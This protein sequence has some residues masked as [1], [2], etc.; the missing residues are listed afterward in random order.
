MGGLHCKWR[1]PN[2]RFNRHFCRL[3]SSPSFPP[4]SSITS[5]P[6]SPLSQTKVRC[7]EF[8]TPNTRSRAL[9][10]RPLFCLSQNQQTQQAQEDNDRN[11]DDDEEEGEDDDSMSQG[12]GNGNWTIVLSSSLVG[13]L[14]GLGVVLFNYSVHEI[15]DVI[16]DEIPQRGASW[17]REEPI[18]DMWQ[19]V[20][21]VP[22]AG[23]S[24]V[25]ILNVLRGA[26]EDEQG[27]EEEKEE[28]VLVKMG[29]PVSVFD[30][31]K[32]ASR[33][34]LKAVAACVTLGTGNSLGP[35]GPSVEIGTSIAKGVGAVF[36]KSSQRK[37][38]LVAAG[39]AA[40]IASGFN[41][42]VSGCFFA[43]ESVLWPSPADS[44]S[45]SVSLTN[46]TSMVILSAVIAS[47]VTQVGLGSEPA[48]K[49]P[50]YDFR[51]PTELPLYLLL[52]VLC[53]LVSLTFSKCTSYMLLVVDNLQKATS[54]PRSLFPIL[55]GLSVGLIA[56]AYP[57]IL[58]WGFENVDILLESRP[59]VKGLSADLLVQL[60]VVKI[61]ATSLCRASG[62]VGGYY[63]PSL[64]IGAATGMAYGK[65]I[66]SA[67]AQSNPLLHLSYL[68]VAS[69]QAYGLVGMAATLAGVC[70]VPLTAVLLLFELTQDYRI[71]LPL[72][73]AVGLSSWVTSGQ[74]RRKDVSKSKK[75]SKGET[76]SIQQPKERFS[77][78]SGLSSRKAFTESTS[79]MSDLCEM[80]S[81]LCID[82]FDIDTEKLEK[83]ILV[84]EAMRT[85]YVTVWMNTSLTEA[86]AL[87]LAE[88]QPCAMIVDSD[89]VLIGILT[90]EDIQKFSNKYAK[91]RKQPKELI[92]YEMCSSDGEACKVPGTATPSMDLFSAQNI[93][94]RYEMNEIPVVTE[95]PQD[96]RGHLVGLLDRD[97]ISLTCR[98]LATRE[99]LR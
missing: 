36:D 71:V 47:V 39:S 55:G 81:S 15:R 99:S 22:A 60:V 83:K 37:L 46:T 18:T 74:T 10:L 78:V 44:S 72:L 84:S 16:W 92:V 52:G 26:L 94:N 98:A 13:L 58:Y 30:S 91:S 34:F 43:V 51:S 63:A 38:S 77:R 69:P 12:R 57:E 87:M 66:G 80:E 1:F 86:V 59:F 62:L 48:F 9:I 89:Q 65:F 7:V 14:T 61:G 53:G 17:L 42:A 49:V 70:Q 21:F 24:I 5:L 97:C 41:A 67:V 35:E 73:G 90:L 95:H 85:R 96:Q 31:L 6:F 88:K 4:F 82:D 50:G 68:E 33:P 25:A 45:S 32:A 11:N 20:V 3:P 40:G 64:F 56:L 93:M 76:S 29:M 2:T 75:L 27:E 8:T 28:N 19:R 79:N 23:G 54:L